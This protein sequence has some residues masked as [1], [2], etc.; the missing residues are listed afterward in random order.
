[1]LITPIAPVIAP[2]A[3][4]KKITALMGSRPPAPR[5]SPPGEL[6]K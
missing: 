4:M 2:I 6:A 5:R 3:A 1:M